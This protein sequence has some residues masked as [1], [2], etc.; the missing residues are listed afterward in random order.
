M[1]PPGL[2][3]ALPPLGRQ[4]LPPRDSNRKAM[5]KAKPTAN[6]SDYA[7]QVPG[8]SELLRPDSSRSQLHEVSS[9]RRVEEVMTDRSSSPNENGRPSS[10]QSS[11]TLDSS[12]ENTRLREEIR[13]LQE[14]LVQK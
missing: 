8:L 4:P 5:M 12:E 6:A 7:L 1:A 10:S 13:R 9:S 3:K 2:Q 14:S 11:E